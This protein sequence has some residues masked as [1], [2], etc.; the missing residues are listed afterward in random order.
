[1][2]IYICVYIFTHTHIDDIGNAGE[3]GVYFYYK[4]LVAGVEM[5]AHEHSMEMDTKQPA[6]FSTISAKSHVDMNQ[7]RIYMRCLCGVRGSEGWSRCDDCDFT[8]MR[9]ISNVK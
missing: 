2:Y 3:Q 5:Y 1:M 8:S 6:T 7:V 9:H 4:N